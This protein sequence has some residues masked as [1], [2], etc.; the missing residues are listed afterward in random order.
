MERDKKN[1]EKFNFCFATKSERHEVIYVFIIIATES[2]PDKN[3]RGQASDTEVLAGLVFSANH[4]LQASLFASFAFV[5]GC[6][7][8]MQLLCKPAKNNLWFGRRGK[9]KQL[10]MDLIV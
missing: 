5:H 1:V 8:K 3:I 6:I 2:T 10:D 4:A 9:T 7:R